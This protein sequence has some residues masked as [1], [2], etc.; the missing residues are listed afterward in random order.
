MTNLMKDLFKNGL[1]EVRRGFMWLSAFLLLGFLTAYCS[2]PSD[3]DPDNSIIDKDGNGLIEISSLLELH[4]IRYNL[5]GTSYKIS[6]DDEGD[7]TGCPTQPYDHDND[8]DTDDV[9]GCTGYELTQ[10][11]DFDKD[12]DSKTFEGDCDVIVS[13]NSPRTDFSNCNIDP[14]D[15]E[16]VYFPKTDNDNQGWLPIGDCGSD[17]NCGG[18]GSDDD[19][20]FTAVFEGNGFTIKNLYLKRNIVAGGLF[21]LTGSTVRVR[22]IGMQGGGIFSCSSCSSNSYSGGLV[23]RNTGTISDSHATGDV[24]SSVSSPSYAGGLVG[25]NAGTI[26]NSYAT[27]SASGGNSGGLVGENAGTI[28]DS[29]ATG[30]ASSTDSDAGGLVGRNEGGITN[31]YATGSAYGGNSGGLVG[32]NAGTITDSY[33]TGSS[34][35]AFSSGGLVGRNSG[36]ITNSYATSSSSSSFSFFSSGAGGL[37]GFNGNT[38]TITNS[39]ATG[40]VSSPSSSGGL[41][42]S[43]SGSIMNS[44]ATGSVSSSSSP[45]SSGG[46]V[47]ENNGDIEN[48]Y[49]T[50]SVSSPSSSGG[51]VGRNIGDITNSYATGSASGGNSGGLVGENAGTITNSYATISASGSSDSGGLVGI[52]IGDITNSYATGSVSGGSYSGGLVGENRERGTITNSYA[53]G[54]ASGGNSGGL[55]GENAGTI[56][57]SYAT[58]SASGGSY[59]GGLVGINSGDITKSYATGSASGSFSSSGGLAGSNRGTITNSYAT[60]SASGSA[61]GGLVGINSGTITNSYATGSASAS[62]AGGLVGTRGTAAAIITNSYWNSETTGQT[63]SSGTGASDKTTAEMYSLTDPNWDSA[64]WNFG[65]SSEY[66]GLCINQQFHRPIQMGMGTS[67]TFTVTPAGSCGGS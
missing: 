28:T 63:S 27:G 67:A 12:G 21:G 50:G 37:V 23:G 18:S 11:L 39:Y 30:S 59:S 49:A 32:E 4:N 58:G 14:D 2:D 55:V 46:L 22:N 62:L 10:D 34:A 52:N 31:S 17:N 16:D 36:D 53:T 47:G 43:N 40:S 56:T 45:S 44:Y 54:D 7:S 61:A 33:A 66:P 65:T 9:M 3:S 26:T 13:G 41:V 42:G 19:S 48:S 60:G 6:A 29:Y 8:P 64:I 35:A 38:G 51:L 57:N 15:V 1:R 5:A 24:S 20:P 25:E